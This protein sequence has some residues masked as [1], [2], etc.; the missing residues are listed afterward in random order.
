MVQREGWNDTTNGWM[1][2]AEVL[3]LMQW[4]AAQSEKPK[5]TA[6]DKHGW[7]VERIKGRWIT[8]AIRLLL[9]THRI[10]YW[11]SSGDGRSDR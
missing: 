6:L 3:E 1:S 4:A 9:H 11:P 8:N 5:L 2:P 7:P 10:G